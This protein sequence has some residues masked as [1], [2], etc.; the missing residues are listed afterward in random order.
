MNEQELG[1]LLIITEYFEAKHRSLAMQL[2]YVR[3]FGCSATAVGRD[4]VRNGGCSG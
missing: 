4:V 3:S 1:L 2:N